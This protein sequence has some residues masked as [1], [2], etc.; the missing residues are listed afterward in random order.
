MRS[1]S[2]PHSKARS[3]A[4][5]AALVLLALSTGRGAVASPPAVHIVNM[6]GTG[7]VPADLT[8]TLGDTVE[9]VNKD[10]FP[11]TATSDTGGFDSK[12]IPAGKSWKYTTTKKGDFDYVCTYHDNMTGTLHVR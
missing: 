5:A 9:W 10:P 11:H 4:F 3:S 12:K 2:R 6:D 8:V 1:I 7:F